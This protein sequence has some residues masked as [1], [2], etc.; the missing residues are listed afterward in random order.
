MQWVTKPESKYIIPKLVRVT[1]TKNTF[2]LIFIDYWWCLFRYVLKCVIF[3]EVSWVQL[4]VA[5]HWACSDAH[6]VI[7]LQD[8]CQ[9]TLMW[10]QIFVYFEINQSATMI[11]NIE[12]LQ[13]SVFAW[14]TPS[15]VMRQILYLIKLLI[16]Y[17]IFP[18][19]TIACSFGPNITKKQRILKNAPN[20]PISFINRKINNSRFL[21]LLLKLKVINLLKFL[22]K[23]S[24]TISLW[25]NNIIIL[26]LFIIHYFLYCT[27]TRYIVYFC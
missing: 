6:W 18:I 17:R 7:S 25:F 27:L 16:T 4:Y 9:W 8:L 10:M 21:I 14:Y 11:A 3:I 1:K 19:D 26:H 5:V 12:Q 2:F 23:Y 20:N 15:F 22:I 24:Y 13:L